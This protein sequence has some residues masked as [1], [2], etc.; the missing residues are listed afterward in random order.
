MA[1]GTL[2]SNLYASGQ[3]QSSVYPGTNKVVVGYFTIPANTSFATTDILKMMQFPG[4]TSF[5]DEFLIDWPA[6]D[7]G[8]GLTFSMVDTLASPTTFFTGNTVA[9]AGGWTATTATAHGDLG[10]ASIA[11]AGYFRVIV[12]ILV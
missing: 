9:Q 7:A 2:S 1:L 4:P 8:A 12:V 10:A 5:F 11:N 3:Q 6:L